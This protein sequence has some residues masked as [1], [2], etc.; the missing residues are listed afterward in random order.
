LSFIARL[1]YDAKYITEQEAWEYIDAAYEQAQKTFQ[2]WEELA[3]S[4]V[5]G[6]F[7]WKGKDADDDIQVIAEDL[8]S[9]AKSPWT[10]VAWK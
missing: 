6:R 4:Y 3:K 2:S 7:I 5:I 10:Q 8:V 1:C 9:N